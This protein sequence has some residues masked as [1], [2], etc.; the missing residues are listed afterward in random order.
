MQRRAATGY[1]ALLLVVSA[2]SF[3]LSAAAT[4]PPIDVTADHELRANESV[5]LEGTRYTVTTLNASAPAATL[6]W[7]ANGTNR[8]TTLEEGTNVTLGG[9]TYTA[10]FEGRRLQLTRDQA[11]YVAEVRAVE[12]HHALMR[13]LGVVGTLSGLT[14][15][16][17]G[18]AAFMPV[19][20]D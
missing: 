8:S 9:T 17:L 5:R 1:L 10:H 14:G 16:V 2:G 3:G 18:A 6:E 7:T 13:R 20:G 12:R 15:V 4:P 19:R 11:A